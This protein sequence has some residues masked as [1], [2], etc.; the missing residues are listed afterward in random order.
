MGVPE[1]LTDWQCGRQAL[2]QLSCCSL[3][4]RLPTFPSLS[5]SLGPLTGSGT[6]C[7]GVYGEG[8]K[9]PTGDGASPTHLPELRCQAK[10]EQTR[11]W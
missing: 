1:I 5:L 7:Q 8:C 4:G 10:T 11:G 3:L 2:S 9:D 6:Y